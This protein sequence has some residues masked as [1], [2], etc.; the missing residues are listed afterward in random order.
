MIRWRRCP[1]AWLARPAHRGVRTG[2]AILRCRRRADGPAGSHARLAAADAE[3]RASWWATAYRSRRPATSACRCGSQRRGPSSNARPRRRPARRSAAF[4]GQGRRP[5][6]T[7]I[8][9]A[10]PTTRRRPRSSTGRGSNRGSP[11]SRG[12][13]GRPTNS[14]PTAKSWKWSF[15]PEP[16][17]SQA[18]VLVD[19]Q[20]VEGRAMADD[21]LL[22]P[23]AGQRDRASL[24]DRVA[25]P[26]SGAAASAR[27]MRLEFPQLGPNAWVR[28]MY[29]QLILPANEHVT[30]NPAGF[31]GEFTWDWEGYFW[32]RQPL[33]DQAQLEVVGRRHAAARLARTRQPLP[34]QHAG[35][36][37]AGRNPYRRPDVDRALGLGRGAGGRPVVDLR[38]RQPSPGHAAGGGP[39]AVGRRADRS[40]A[41]VLAGPGRQPGIGADAAGGT[42]GARH[43]RATPSPGVAQGTVPVADRSGFDPHAPRVRRRSTARRLPR[44]CRRSRRHPRG[45]PSDESPSG[46]ASVVGRDAAGRCRWAGGRRR[47]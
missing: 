29:W 44:A 27:R 2:V 34:V 18:V 9:A 4:G 24:R 8:C 33:L 19:G 36:R 6:S 26:F 23:L 15:R 5:A 1:C 25:I 16:P 40:R 45:M 42:L 32:G 28:R 37:A 13:I 43:E 38:A 17:A 21:R 7:W 14:P 11:R 41:D 12:K 46:A 30:A 39:G 31:T 47:G 10:K 35:R 22:V 3:G 20:R